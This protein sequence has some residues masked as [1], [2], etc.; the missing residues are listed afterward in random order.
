LKISERLRLI[1]K[2]FKNSAG[3]VVVFVPSPAQGDADAVAAIAPGIS[4]GKIGR[5]LFVMID[6]VLHHFDEAVQYRSN[7]WGPIRRI[8]LFAHPSDAYDGF[9]TVSEKSDISRVIARDWW[10]SRQS[11][12]VEML[13]AHVCHGASILRKPHWVGVFENWISFDG[14]VD[15]YVGSALG[16]ERWCR[17][18]GRTIE[19]TVVS[20]TAKSLMI[21]MRHAYENEILSIEDDPDWAAGDVINLCNF[22]RAIKLLV[23][24]KGAD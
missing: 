9:V 11:R 22:E 4:R 23:D 24:D 15:A 17:I 8:V 20:P 3:V 1:W 13:V 21:R 16:R 19:A 14:V 18:A 7:S 12:K 10:V 6:R 2:K 5:P